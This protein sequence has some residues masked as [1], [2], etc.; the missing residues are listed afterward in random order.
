MTRALSAGS[1]EADDG[2][3]RVF[4]SMAAPGFTNG[5]EPF[6]GSVARRTAGLAV[7]L[8]EMPAQLSLGAGTVS[9]PFSGSGPFW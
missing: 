8:L 7:Q 5:A 6:E 3:L 1:G 9:E 4:A 2:E